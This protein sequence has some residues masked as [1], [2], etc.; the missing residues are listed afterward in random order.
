[1]LI[2]VDM[3]LH[4][5]PSVPRIE[6]IVPVLRLAAFNDPAWLFEPKYDGFRGMV[7]LTGGKCTIYSKRGNAF[8]KFDALRQRLCA[9]LP[10]LDVILDGEIIAID[11]EG[12]MDFW[13]LMKGRGHLAYAAFD[14][15]WLRGKDLRHLPL[16][17]R[18]KRLVRLLPDAVGPLN[19]I[20]WFEEN[21]RELFQATRQYDL[22]GIVAKRK[23][24]PYDARARWLKIKNP[25]YTQAEGRR[26][27]FG[28]RSADCSAA[29][30]AGP[31]GPD[32]DASLYEAC[33]R[34]ISGPGCR[35]DCCA[36]GWQGSGD[37]GSGRCR[38]AG[39]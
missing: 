16:I 17:Q 10:R 9:E 36:H 23:A 27:L 22:E 32:H 5:L 4:I 21:G 2:P 8:S 35:R 1:M 12:R 14:I 29:E 11:G 28:R 30:L 31:C 19:L 38:P 25:T 7:Y 34:G 39:P 6:P 26:E 3:T 20:P 13:G 33:A 18:K 37:S 15:L 24:D